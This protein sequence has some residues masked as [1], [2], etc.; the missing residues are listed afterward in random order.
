MTSGPP[1]IEL[2]QTRQRRAFNMDGLSN[3]N[4]GNQS[5]SEI[6]FVN[7]TS[8]RVADLSGF[9]KKTHQ[10]PVELSEYTRAFVARIAEQDLVDDLDRQFADLRRHFKFKRSQM[11]V[12]DPD[13]GVGAIVTPQFEYR[14]SIQIDE[15][16]PSMY[17]RT[18]E[19]SRLTSPEALLSAEFELA[20]GEMF[21]AIEV[22]PPGLINMEDF[23]DSV[24]DMDKH[25]LKIDFDRNATWCQLSILRVPGE[26]TVYTNR[27]SL[28]L[29]Q[30]FPPTRLIDAFFQFR[31]ELKGVEF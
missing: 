10:V 16:D 8:G 23:I 15:S 28:Q 31:E 30:T 2:P 17:V 27:I 24:E 6:S 13:D 1:K 14:A 18:Q 9:K 20:Y 21:N 11:E 7:R 22:T 25:T 26:M 12:Q 4:A 29:T 3:P 19:V 5:V